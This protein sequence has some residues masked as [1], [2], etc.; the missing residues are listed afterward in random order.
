MYVGEDGL[1]KY[2]FYQKPCASR[3]AIPASSA[4]SKQQKLSVMVEE[5]LRR[6]RN[7]SRGLEW[8]V[9]RRCM[10]E[11]ARKLQRSG[12]PATFRHQVIRAAINK[13][14]KMCKDDDEG[15]RPVHRAREWHLAARRLE[16]ER[17]REDW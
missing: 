16:K 15:L 10:E 1:I 7:H 17:K 9:R 2:E 4:H 3:L 6:L 5:G 12:Y 8:E 13:W 11:W 14:E